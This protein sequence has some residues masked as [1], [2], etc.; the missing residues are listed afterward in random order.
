MN[1]S[2][3]YMLV[4]L[5]L[6]ALA[7][8]AFFAYAGMLRRILALNVMASGIFLLLVALARQG[9]GPADP[10]PHAMVLT[11]IVVSVSA[12]AFALALLDRLCRHKGDDDDDA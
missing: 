7:L 1:L 12:T 8:H 4:A 9:D 6:V 5:G 10:V 3:L 2:L 11:G